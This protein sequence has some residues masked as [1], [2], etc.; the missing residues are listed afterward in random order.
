MTLYYHNVSVSD[1]NFLI[2]WIL[3]VTSGKKID[4]NSHNS[5]QIFVSQ[6]GSAQWDSWFIEKKQ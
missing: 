4:L 2:L 5:W 6:M 1:I 3:R